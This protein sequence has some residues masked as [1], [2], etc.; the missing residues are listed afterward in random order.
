VVKD[1]DVVI[2]GETI[3]LVPIVQRA[4]WLLL[5]DAGLDVSFMAR[6]LARHI[7]GPG[8]SSNVRWRDHSLNVD[9]KS[10][11][12]LEARVFAW[13]MAEVRRRQTQEAE[14]LRSFPICEFRA[15]AGSCETAQT[16]HRKTFASEDPPLVPLPDCRNEQCWCS[17]RTQS[18]RDLDP[19]GQSLIEVV[20]RSKTSHGTVATVRLVPRGKK[21]KPWWRFWSF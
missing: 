12:A 15:E 3:C 6:V 19:S 11:A 10:L 1:T 7:G 8:G 18:H 17:L 13:T 2:A 20:Q 16:L 4:L 9:E 14:V 21:S 5:P